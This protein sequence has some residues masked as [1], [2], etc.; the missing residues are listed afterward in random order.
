MAEQRRIGDKWN[1]RAVM[2]QRN[3]SKSTELMPLL[4][5]RAPGVA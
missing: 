4:R 1:L 3:P 2:A 5:S